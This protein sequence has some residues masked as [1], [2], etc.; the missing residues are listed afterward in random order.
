MEIILTSNKNDQMENRECTPHNMGQTNTGQINGGFYKKIA[1]AYGWRT[2]KQFK[3]YA[4]NNCKLSKSIS[5]RHY[6]L[7]CRRK[8]LIPSFIESRVNRFRCMFAKSPVEKKVDTCLKS[9]MDKLLNLCIEENSV[10]IYETK[11]RMGQIKEKFEH[12]A[13]SGLREAWY[14]FE[15]QNDIF[16]TASIQKCNVTCKRKLDRLHSRN[17]NRIEWNESAVV[18]MT[19]IEVPAEVKM[20]LSF[21]PKFAV[22]YAPEEVPLLR[23]ITDC[24]N[25][26]NR[27]SDD[28]KKNTLR[29]KVANVITNRSYKRKLNWQDRMF[30][31][32]A[33]ETASFLRR[34][35]NVVIA[36]SD[37]GKKTI[38]MYKEEYHR[39]VM[40]LLEDGETYR[41]MD[42]DPTEKVQK[43]LNSLID[44]LAKCGYVEQSMAKQVMTANAIPPKMY[45]LIKTHKEGEP[46]RPVI[47]TIG[48]AVYNLSKY[49]ASILKPLVRTDYNIKN[50]ME[51]RDDIKQVKCDENDVLVSFDVKSLF[52]KIPL[53]RLR[54]ILREKWHR[55]KQRTIMS[56]NTFMAL[57]EICIKDGSY[58][59]YNGQ[60]YM[61]VEGLPM[62]SALS[63][64]LAAIVLDALM[65]EIMERISG[66]VKLLKKY[67]DDFIAVIKI[68]HIDEVLSVL[69]GYNSSIQFTVEKEVNRTLPF[70]DMVLHREVDGHVLTEWY[71][72]ACSSGRLLSFHSK[73]PMKQRINTAKG[74]M[75]RVISLTDTEYLPAAV[76]KIVN[77]LGKNHYPKHIVDGLFG[78]WEKRYENKMEKEKEVKKYV[79]MIYVAGYTEILSKIFQKDLDVIVAPKAKNTMKTVFP[80]LKDSD[81]VTKQSNAIYCVPCTICKA[82]YIGQTKRYVGVRLKEHEKEIE[83]IW[84]RPD[85]AAKH[86]ECALAEHYRNFGHD[87][88]FQ[89]TKILDRERNLD[90]RRTLEALHIWTNENTCN[91]R[92]D[93]DGISKIYSDI[94]TKVKRQLDR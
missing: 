92:T 62:G 31:D 68:E 1:H 16:K 75:N 87:M 63:P 59:V 70:L 5:R 57:I 69:N 93:T 15:S 79:G 34:N 67:V 26:C 39:K 30:K 21:G 50:S 60:V 53:E 83:K 88:D 43:N 13:V 28:V 73:H 40:Q 77:I 49:L 94:L 82:I 65:E 24:E 76:E 22:D 33:D 84:E 4:A 46:G 20:M 23:L 41:R 27:E 38:V 74:L 17:M 72:K 14:S 64:V 52:T 29:G 91:E 35:K 51:A 10:T 86:G 45:I 80:I 55:I 61:Q 89:K 3:L 58:F 85:E 54:R 37:K 56:Q 2:Q 9:F 90:K 7:K 36:Q 19:N 18:N 71:E 81:D 47:S 66:Y 48:S 78:E 44:K 11:R 25:I 12:S 8:R 42:G 6:L 32:A